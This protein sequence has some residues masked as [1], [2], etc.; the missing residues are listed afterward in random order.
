MRAFA[1]FALVL[2]ACLIAPAFGAIN[3]VLSYQGSLKDSSGAP[4]P[5][6][7]Y[8]IVFSIYD[9][10]TGGVGLWSETQILEVKNGLVHAYLGSV[11]SFDPAIFATSPLWLGIRLES[12]PEFTPRHVI[13]STVYSFVAGNALLLEGY[14][15]GHFADSAMV[16]FSIANHN[17][18]SSAHHPLYVD[19][20]EIVSGTLAPERLPLIVVDSSNVTDG[21]IVGADLADSVISSN[22]LQ[23]AAVSRVH[24]ADHA[25]GSSQVE[26]GSL[27]GDDL[28]DSTITGRQIAAGAISAEHLSIAAF[29]GSSIAD[30]SLTGADLA[31]STITG[32]KIAAGSIASTHL[33]NIAITGA[34]ITDGTI[35][36]ADIANASIGFNDIGP[37]QI[38]GY[39]IQDGSLTGA[40]IAANSITG[41]QISDESLSGADIAINSIADRHVA[42]NTISSA[43]L[44]DEPGIAETTGGTLTSVGTTV[45]NWMSVTLDAPA[46]GYVLVLMNGLANLGGNE[47]AQISIST[48]STGFGHYG[49]ARVSSGSGTTG[50]NFTVSISEAIPVAAAGPVTIYGNVRA[51]VLSAGLIDMSQGSMQVIYIATGY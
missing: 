38:A 36:G 16:N 14:S 43:K 32:S 49:E 2:T 8:S 4:F 19:A 13:G 10:S 37:Q 28:Q 6:G 25:V 30:G 51:S 24:L 7:N 3:P 48:T 34:Q 40:D 17:A 22:K 31:D 42:S 44:L 5:D 50:G 41:T 20:S 15:A 39:H 18:D 12:E 27:S 1:I 33:S 45:V 29:D 9:D 26:D 21:S 23:T 11:T 47:G 35:T 46:P